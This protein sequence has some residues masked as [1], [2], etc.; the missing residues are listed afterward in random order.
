MNVEE[1]A[2]DYVTKMNDPKK[3]EACLTPDAMV[4]GSVLPQPIPGTEALKILSAWTNALPDIKFDVGQVTLNGNEATV[5]LHWG[6][7]H[8][9][10]LSLPMPGMPTVPPTGKKV[11]VEDTYGLT[12]KG[13]KVSYMRLESPADGGIPGALAKL[14]VKMP[15]M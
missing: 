1:I 10:P 14:G 8:T 4:S 2:R 3:I 13:D 11:W 6:G 15:G 12:V 7:T 9:A 5:H